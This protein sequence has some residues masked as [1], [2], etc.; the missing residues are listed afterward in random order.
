MVQHA[1]THNEV[2]IQVMCTD[3]P[4]A[5]SHTMN[6][7]TKYEPSPRTSRGNGTWVHVRHG[8]RL[9]RDV[10]RPR[11]PQARLRGY[12]LEATERRD[13]AHDDHQ[14]QHDDARPRREHT[15]HHNGRRTAPTPPED[16]LC[17]HS[18]IPGQHLEHIAG[19]SHRTA[20]NRHDIWWTNLY[21][22]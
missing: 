5:I 15:G 20:L 13:D 22:P 3:L 19:T 12:S 10:V 21:D 7:T 16:T 1:R 9:R 11:R 17:R 8:G 4:S 14:D 18:G 2:A 6:P